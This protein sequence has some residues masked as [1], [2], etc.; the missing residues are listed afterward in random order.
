MKYL[1]SPPSLAQAQVRRDTDAM[2][3]RLPQYDVNQNRHMR[4]VVADLDFVVLY[5]TE[6]RAL[7]APITVSIS[8]MAMRKAAMKPRARNPLV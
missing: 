6:R 3:A 5:V 1:G 8:P 7:V 4:A 2:M